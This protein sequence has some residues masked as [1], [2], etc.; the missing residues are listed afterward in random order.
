M[1]FVESIQTVLGKY[2]AFSGRARRSEYWWF[3]LFFFL[4]AIVAAVVDSALGL[5]LGNDQ[6]TFSDTGLVS[7]VV[8]LALLIPWLAVSVRR[9]HDT[10]RSG[11]LVLLGLI[12]IVGVILLIIW[13]AQDSKPGAN[14]HGPNPKELVSAL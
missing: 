9:L 2:A 12:P 10:G 11:W 1:S 8:T 7:A 13:F 4:V 6:S 14:A 5:Q 3:I